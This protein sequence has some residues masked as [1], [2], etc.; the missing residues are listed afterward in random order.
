MPAGERT[1]DARRS[2]SAAVFVAGI[3]IGRLVD[4]PPEPAPSGGRAAPA[5]ELD[6]AEATPAER[7]AD[8]RRRCEA[9]RTSGGAS[10]GGGGAN[11]TAA[12]TGAARRPP[13]R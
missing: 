13:T 1:G 10:G 9:K 12:D 7:G 5:A 8:G 4:S 11:G 2:S 6:Q 3:G